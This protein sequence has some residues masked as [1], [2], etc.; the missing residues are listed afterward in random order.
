MPHLRTLRERKARGQ[1]FHIPFHSLGS[2]EKI[3][4]TRQ[5]LGVHVA[6]THYCTPDTALSEPTRKSC[7]GSTNLQMLSLESLTPGVGGV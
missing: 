7:W 6:V 3:A 4:D 2:V 1:A 5:G